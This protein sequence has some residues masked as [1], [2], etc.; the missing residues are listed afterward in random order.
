MS[1]T[2]DRHTVTV[3]L[4]GGEPLAVEQGYATLDELWSPFAQGGLTVTDPADIA[5]LD[6]RVGSPRVT[7]TMLR[8][9][10]DSDTVADLTAAYGAGTVAGLTAL[11]GAGTVAGLSAAHNRNWVPGETRSPQHRTIDLGVRSR[12]R[13]ADGS[14]TLGLAS[15]EALLLDYAP[16]G[17]DDDPGH[18]YLYAD[19]DNLTASLRSLVQW[20]VLRVIPDAV[21]APIRV[22][23]AFPDSYVTSPSGNGVLWL[24]GLSAWAFLTPYLQTAG[25]RLWCDETRVWHL[26]AAPVGAPGLLELEGTGSITGFTDGLSRDGESDWYNAVVVVYEW[27][28]VDTG[29]HLIRTDTA[30]DSS[31]WPALPRVMSVRHTETLYPGPGAAAK[32]LARS[33]GRGRSIPVTATSDYTANPGMAVTVTPE[34]DDYS[35]VLASV[36][37]DFERYEMEVTV[38]DVEE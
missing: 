11:Y 30:P 28:D 34:A 23:Q 3:A 37:W 14:L 21:F 4:P 38:R 26:D 9:F 20:V 31:I 22:D 17:S 7:F 10:S 24:A 13:N 33:I 2:I 12:V 6:P 19:P 8:E 36:R 29:E 5:D 35:A 16:W 32:L 1:V 18:A 27:D 15:D 25:F